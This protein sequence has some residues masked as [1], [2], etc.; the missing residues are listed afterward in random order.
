MEFEKHETPVPDRLA[1]ELISLWETIFET[2]YEA[3]RPV[4]R[5]SERRDNR[6]M[7]YI[8]RHGERLVGTC[9]LTVPKALPVIAG[10][11]EVATAAD[12]RRKGIGRQLCQA[13]RDDF[14]KE[15]GRAVFLGTANPAAV[16][17]YMQLGWEKIPGSN[18]M[19]NIAGQ[20]SY[21]RFLNSY[22]GG[23]GAATCSEGSPADRVPM[24]PLLVWP[25]KQRV[26]DANTEMYSTVH[27]VQCSCMG[28][29]PRYEAV[30]REG[31][32]AWFAARTD[33]GKTVGLST[34]RLTDAHAARIDAF[35]HPR[36]MG[37]WEQLATAAL[38]W[39]AS[40]GATS[41]SALLCEEDQEKLSR[42]AGLGFHVTGPGPPFVLRQREV[43]SVRMERQG[44]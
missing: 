19:V 38:K 1:D 28:L 16:Q 30:P 35:A 24:I 36:F 6:D 18:V 9:R 5:G 13:A 34:V 8:F 21:E 12:F 7:I 2:S 27:A 3:S 26:L 37:A 25:H 23:G 17:L 15:G 31:K 32:G 33:R 41:C 4:L 20:G 43:G 29:Y 22:F 11:G 39:S 10:L 40:K 14:W 42:F 44:R